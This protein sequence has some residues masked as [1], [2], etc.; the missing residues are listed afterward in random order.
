MTWRRERGSGTILALA[1]VL[2]VFASGL[3]L[4]A[5]AQLV[6]ARA[7][8]VTAADAAALAAAPATF[9]ALANDARPEQLAAALA[10]ANGARLLRCL[11]PTVESFDP[12]HVEV[13]VA[14]AT[15]IAIVGGVEVRAVSR[16][17]YVP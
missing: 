7:R 15:Q 12:R 13:E 2:V 11:C 1:L 10:Q 8:A 3:A 17:E 9:P 16:A 14:V 5:A 6:T 4:L